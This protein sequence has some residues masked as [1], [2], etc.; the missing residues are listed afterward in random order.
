[1]IGE[2]VCRCTKP[3]HCRTAG[4]CMRGGLPPAVWP[5]PKPAKTMTPQDVHAEKLRDDY[6]RFQIAYDRMRRAEPDNELGLV[7]IAADMDRARDKWHDYV[8]VMK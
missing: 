4:F 7:M 2:D 5:D 3:T 1:M 6:M 8:K